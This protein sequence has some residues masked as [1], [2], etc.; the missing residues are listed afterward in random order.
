MISHVPR[1]SILHLEIF[2]IFIND[3]DS[4]I[5]CTPSK[6]TDDT[7]QSGVVDT[8]EGRDVIKRDLAKLEKWSHVNLMR[9]TRPSATY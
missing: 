4:G 3:L 7:K 9:F 5:K 6:L 2:K 8:T 1:G